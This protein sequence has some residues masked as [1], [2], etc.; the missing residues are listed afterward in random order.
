MPSFLPHHLHHA[1]SPRF[2]L[3][4]GHQASRPTTFSCLHERLFFSAHRSKTMMYSEEMPCSAESSALPSTSPL[5][6][7][8][9]SSELPASS[10]SLIPPQPFHRT[11]RTS[12]PTPPH[13]ISSAA[14]PLFIDLDYTKTG[15]PSPE[16][17]HD[18]VTLRADDMVHFRC[19]RTERKW[20]R[21]D[22]DV[23]ALFY[24]LAELNV[25]VRQRQ[26]I[27]RHTRTSQ[28]SI[29]DWAKNDTERESFGSS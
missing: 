12:S 27:S 15:F 7:S 29:E 24:K 28:G 9:S 19:E 16:K 11:S 20:N 1:P 13:T 8:S 22:M 4:L 6:P 3:G 14:R 25:T 10:N 21:D 23:D 5:Q 18:N 26:I 17:N 2:L